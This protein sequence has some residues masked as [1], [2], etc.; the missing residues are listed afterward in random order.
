MSVAGSLDALHDRL[1]HGR[2]RTRGLYDRG[3]AVARLRQVAIRRAAARRLA[4]PEASRVPEED[5]FHVLPHYA[6]PGVEAVVR[7]ARRLRAETDTSLASPLWTAS[8]GRNLLRVRLAPRMAD[9]P[10][11]TAFAVDPTLLSTVARY[12]GSVPLLSEAQ[13]WISPY[14]THSPDGRSLEC[15]WH[16]DW[17]SLRQ[18]RV[19]VF[20]EDVTPDHGPLTLV[21]ARRSAAVRRALRYT[22]QERD[23]ALTDEDFFAHAAP[24]EARGLC[25]PAG[26]V[27]FA[28]TCRCFHHGSRLRRP[29]L[30]R[31]MAMFQYLPVTAFKLSSGFVRRSPF[32]RLAAAGHS[33]LQRRVLGRVS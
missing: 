23:C 1:S 26:T 21:P 8:Q 27:A 4:D 24:D 31:V 2:E 19:L 32:A 20:V 33:E 13:L 14:A 10:E 17:S 25:G 7:A 6:L 22:F 28:D 29:G 9:E 5:G 30:E 3:R 12:L 11:W 18:L 15:R 16:C